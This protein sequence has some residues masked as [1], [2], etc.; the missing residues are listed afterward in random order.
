MKNVNCKRQIALARALI[1]I[2]VLLALAMPLRAQDEAPAKKKS[3]AAKAHPA[4][5]KSSG[6]HTRPERRPTAADAVVAPLDDPAVVALLATKPAT[7]AEWARTAKILAD[8]K[9]PD[10]AK[11]FLQKVLDANL[12]DKQLAALADEFG[13]SMF[14]TMSSNEELT[15][16]SAQLASVVLSAVNRKLQDPQRLATLTSQVAGGSDAARNQAIAGLQ[17]AGG[18]GVEALIAVLADPQ[19]AGEHAAVRAALV[20]MGSMAI[21]P[22]AALLDGPGGDVPVEAC[23]ALADLGARHAAV[24]LLRPALAAQSDAKLRDAARAALMKLQGSVPSAAQAVDSLLKQVDVYRQQQQPLQED[25]DGRV[26][27]WRWNADDKRCVGKSYSAENASRAIAARLARDAAAIAPNDPQAQVLAIVTAA[28][29]LADEKGLDSSDL[30]AACETRNR[31][32]ATGTLEKSLEFALAHHAPAAAAAVAQCLGK[33]GD[34]QSLLRGRSAG[35]LSPLVAAV[36]S[37]D[38]RVSLA[39]AQAV[40][41]LQPAAPFPGSSHV[42]EA[43]AFMAGS[44]GTRRALVAGPI[45]E[46]NR[47]VSGLL[48][49]LGYQCDT[50]TSGREALHLTLSSPDYELAMLDASLNNPPV[51]WTLQQL[52]R[53][54]RT[55]RLR[56]GILARP[57]HAEEAERLSHDDPLTCDFAW[58][59]NLTT[60]GWQLKKLQALAPRD[61]VRFDERQKQA[62]QAL[63]CLAH[64]SPTVF[65]VSRAQPALLAALYVPQFGRDVARALAVIG[66]PDSQQALTD[67]ASRTTVAIE[68]RRAAAAAFCRNVA[69]HGILLTTDAI[70]QQYTR[71]NQTAKQDKESRAVLGQVLDGIEAPHAAAAERKR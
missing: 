45:S 67:L 51:A 16:Q 64:L 7:P 2:S 12:D 62:S 23:H 4:P 50:A 35:T 47:A 61:F 58:P 22:L 43:L 55:A 19:R 10:L 71:Y 26:S 24:Y 70:R 37:P 52:R 8:L 33:V 6:T 54:P 69:K 44:R 48:A 28:E 53:D 17:E 25:L 32:V 46:D 39:A 49:A 5:A 11:K 36:C 68:T 40:V 18:A 1:A 34:A 60:I 29:E 3:H 66:T 30:G 41:H 15:P 9:R 31:G 27:L 20:H 14:T 13:T 57:G 42:T 38:R 59:L 63:R 21:D 56:V 65:D